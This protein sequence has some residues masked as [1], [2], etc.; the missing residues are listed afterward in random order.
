METSLFKTEDNYGELQ[1]GNLAIQNLY[2]ARCTESPSWSNWSWKHF[3][4]L[5][6]YRSWKRFRNSASLLHWPITQ[7]R[8]KFF[9][10]LM[11]DRGF[12]LIGPRQVHA[13]YTMHTC[14]TIYASTTWR[15]TS[16]VELAAEILEE[17][18]SG[19]EI[20]EKYMPWELALVE[21]VL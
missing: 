7:Y 9:I 16:G 5:H 11:H 4:I 1:C 14:R 2:A 20:W 17:Q 21:C 19:S 10:S 6:A 3:H 12:G 8:H 13:V 15:V 18:F